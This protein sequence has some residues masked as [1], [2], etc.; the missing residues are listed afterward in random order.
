MTR[1]KDQNKTF[2]ENLNSRHFKIIEYWLEG[3]KASQI[4]KKLNMADTQVRHILNSPQFQHE[5]AIRKASYDCVVNNRIAKVEEDVSETLKSAA[6]QAADT[7]I[8]C[9]DSEDENIKLR[10]A[11]DI[12]DRTGFPKVTRQTSDLSSPSITINEKT[13]VIIADSLKLDKEEIVKGQIA[14]E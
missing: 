6:I 9:M 10:S 3:L 1:F 12:L 2:I 14:K 7:I 8:G 13:A 5:L 11:S 4:A